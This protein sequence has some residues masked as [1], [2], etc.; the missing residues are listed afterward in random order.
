MKICLYCA[1]KEEEN[2]KTR[3]LGIAYIAA[4]LIKEKIVKE[5]DL[6]IADTLDEAI[7]FNPDLLGISSVSQVIANATHFA[8]KCKQATGCLT[9]L[10]GYHISCLPK[11]LPVEFDIGVIGE[12][13]VTF[14]ILVTRLK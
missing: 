2:I 9:V 11:S 8:E 14:S 3:P 10:G 13:E 7:K 5:Q 4:F 1:R 6:L 12:G